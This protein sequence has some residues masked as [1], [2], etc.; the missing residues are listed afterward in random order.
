MRS[1][2]YLGPRNSRGA[3]SAASQGA[4]VQARRG[5]PRAPE[6]LPARP[7]GTA[8]P[9]DVPDTAQHLDLP[10]SSA[11]IGGESSPR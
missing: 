1:S 8:D 2:R 4:T 9:P 10:A 3:S 7:T 11:Q 5:Q 6:S